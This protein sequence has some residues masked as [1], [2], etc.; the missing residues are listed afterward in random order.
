MTW[1]EAKSDAFLT[2]PP[3]HLPTLGQILKIQKF[4]MKTQI[5]KKKYGFITSLEQ[6]GGIPEYQTPHRWR[7]T[8]P[9]CQGPHLS[10]PPPGP[11]PHWCICLS[12][13][14][15]PATHTHTH[16]GLSVST[17]T[18][19]KNPIDPLLTHPSKRR[20]CLPKSGMLLTYICNRQSE[21]Q[22]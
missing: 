6:W 13:P 7:A 1:A 9:M 18:I 16:P 10:G 15:L 20:Q 2:T 21:P 12:V 14:P 17:A 3:W 11:F 19:W 5:K 22:V 8:T 4:L